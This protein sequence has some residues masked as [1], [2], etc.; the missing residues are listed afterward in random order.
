MIIPSKNFH[1]GNSQCDGLQVLH[2]LFA[3]DTLIFCRP[4]ESDLEYLRCT[5]LSFEAMLEL[6]VSLPKSSLITIGEVRNIQYLASF[7]GCGVIAFRFTQ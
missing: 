5:L 6:E 7:F 2:L 1:V 4:S 3:D